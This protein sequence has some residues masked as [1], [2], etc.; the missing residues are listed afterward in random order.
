M[1]ISLSLSIY[2]YIYI[3]THYMTP[4][5]GTAPQSET[6]ELA[7]ICR[8]LRDPVLSLEYYPLL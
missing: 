1:Y 5:L 3:Y 2:I 6:R 7:K 8:N 4:Y